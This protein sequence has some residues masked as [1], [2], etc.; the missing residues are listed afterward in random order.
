MLRILDNLNYDL[1]RF[2]F[3]NPNILFKIS[4]EKD[5]RK[6]FFFETHLKNK[7]GVVIKQDKN[8]K[9]YIDQ[10]YRNSKKVYDKRYAKECF[11]TEDE[12]ISIFK[13]KEIHKENEIENEKIEITKKTIQLMSKRRLKEGFI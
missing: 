2:H 9:Y 11:L 3:H 5:G 1:N 6:I 13:L 4:L 8:R 12:V 7:L 10:L